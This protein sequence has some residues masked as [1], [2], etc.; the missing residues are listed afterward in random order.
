MNSSIWTRDGIIKGTTSLDHSGPGSNGNERVLLFPQNPWLE[1]HHQMLFNFIPTAAPYLLNN[2]RTL[3][4]MYINFLVPQ[5]MDLSS[6]MIHCPSKDMWD[7]AGEARTNLCDILLWTP[8]HGCSSVG[9]LE[10]TYLQQLYTDTECSLEDPWDRW[11]IKTDR[12]RER[13]SQ[14]NLCLQHNLMRM[15]S[16]YW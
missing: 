2:S 13:E 14:G 15:L 16:L 5:S 3:F 6:F 12:E 10:R 9:P 4:W 1:T 11:M 7:T 8:P